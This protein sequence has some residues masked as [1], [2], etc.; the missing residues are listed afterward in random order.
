V[1]H[2]RVILPRRGAAGGVVRLSYDHK[3]YLEDEEDRIRALGGF[4]I[5]ETGRVNGL[6]AVSRS[7]GDFYMHPYVTDEPYLN[8]IE[9]TDNDE[10]LIIA[11]DGVWDEVEDDLAVAVAATETDPFLMSAK[12]RDL[13]YL[14]GSDD[15]ISA[16]VVRLK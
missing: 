14:L 10:F 2:S 5:G 11:C 3:P 15:N 16:A 6:L 7:V 9:L 4:V 8:L 13:A 12:V 1:G